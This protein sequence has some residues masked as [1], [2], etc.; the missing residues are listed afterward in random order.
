MSWKGKILASLV[1]IGSVLFFLWAPHSG[2]KTTTYYFLMIKY[3][4]MALSFNLMAGYVGYISFGHVAFY[5]IGGYVAAILVSKTPLSNTAY[6]CLIAGPLGAALSGYLLGMVLLKLRGAY[7]AIA[8]IA[9]N[10]ALKV[11]MFNLPETFS[12]GTFGIPMPSIRNPAAAYYLM[13][14]CTAAALILVYAVVKSKLGVTLRAIRE[15][16]DGAMAIGINA[17]KYKVWAFTLSTFLMGLAGAIDIFFIG[18]IYPEASF[19]IEVN[20]EVIAMTM[21][22]GLGTVLGPAIG[23]VALFM[24]ADFIWAKWP[25][26]HL[27][28]LGF[29]LCILVLFMRRGVLGLVEEKIP[30]LRGK[31]L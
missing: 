22:G 11:I 27:I 12:G 8:T 5:G 26:S 19:N 2:L 21:L 3:I 23:S 16:E 18:Y 31:I 24:V 29:V 25:F 17:P 15:D 14:F 9:L 13:L 7:F 6:L 10:E 30:S 28:L 1:F 20:V 4:L